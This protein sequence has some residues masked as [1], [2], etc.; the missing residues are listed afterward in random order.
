[1]KLKSVRIRNFRSF[2]D[3]TIEL[4]DYNCL[5]GPNGSGKSSVLVAL[6]VFFREPANPTSVTTLREEDELWSEV[7]YEQK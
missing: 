2:K 5:I 4:G 6:N 3:E 7:V 1:M